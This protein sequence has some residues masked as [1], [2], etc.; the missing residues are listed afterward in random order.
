MYSVRRAT[1]IPP[2]ISKTINR[3]HRPIMYSINT[4]TK[5]KY[6]TPVIEFEMMEEE[7]SVMAGS[8][9]NVGGTGGNQEAGGDNGNGGDVSPFDAKR[10]DFIFDEPLT[11]TDELT[12]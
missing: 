10:T 9:D 6:I 12:W 4:F 11:S 2:N 8:P 7:V 3:H 5:K 1:G